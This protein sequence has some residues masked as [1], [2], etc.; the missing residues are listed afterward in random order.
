MVQERRTVH[1]ASAGLLSPG[2]KLQRDSRFLERADLRQAFHWSLK[3]PHHGRHA[4]RAANVECSVP[5]D[6]SPEVLEE[7]RRH[8]VVPTAQTDPQ[9]VRDYLSALYRYE[10]RRLKGRLLSGEFPQAEYS[11]RVRQL[12]RGYVLLSIPLEIWTPAGTAHSKG[13]NEEPE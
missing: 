6:Y 4:R 2:L 13:Q 3:V 5:Y 12:R 9:L 7:L 10:I 11:G 1:Q 8:G